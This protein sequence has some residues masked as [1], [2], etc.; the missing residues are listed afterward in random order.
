MRAVKKARRVRDSNSKRL[1]IADYEPTARQI[2]ALAVKAYKTQMS[3]VDGYPDKLE[4]LT[5]AKQ[6]WNEACE[7]AGIEIGHNEELIKMVRLAC[8]LAIVPNS[9]LHRHSLLIIP[10]TCE[11]R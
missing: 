3:I 6:S 2:F 9:Y 10:P 8:I 4:E 7:M 11:V 1:K 5:F